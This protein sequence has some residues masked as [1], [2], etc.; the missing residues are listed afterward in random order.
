MPMKPKSHNA[1]QVKAIVKAYDRQRGSS[2][3]RGYSGARWE[4]TRQRIFMRDLYRCQECW[5]RV[6]KVPGDAH[7]DHKTPRPAGAGREYIEGI[8]D[9]ANLRT[10]CRSCHSRKTAR[11]NR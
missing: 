5:C 2:A 1:Q 9:D 3:D 4:A 7:C 6:C 10:L 11:E 8:D